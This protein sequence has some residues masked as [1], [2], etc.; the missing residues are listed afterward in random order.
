MD[1][2]TMRPMAFL[3]VMILSVLLLRG[4]TEVEADK[5]NSS[6]QLVAVANDDTYIE[7]DCIDAAPAAFA[8]PPDIETEPPC[9][10]SYDYLISDFSV[11]WQM[12]E[13]PTGCEITALAMVLQYFGY[14]VDKTA[15]AAEY[16]PVVVYPDFYYG[17]D[18]NLYGPDMRENFVGDP[19]SEWGYICG[20][21][22]VL[23]AA[24]QYLLEEGGG[25]AAADLTGASPQHLYELAAA[26]IP[27]VVWVTIEMSDRY[28]VQGWY[29]A[30]GEYMEWCTQ[31]HCTVLIGCSQNTVTVADPISGITEYDRGRFESVFESRGRQ[32]VI[33]E[34]ATAGT[35]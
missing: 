21:P 26:D 4:K 12:P 28:D 24:N 25:R 14:E 34:E 32:C 18:G 27:V 33:I 1:R 8:V 9:G 23:S 35:V 20:A 2:K 22:A 17:G 6:I 19:F 16:L 11:I 30:S 31:D 10:L 3:A 15:L 29:T 13:L 7:G 5:S